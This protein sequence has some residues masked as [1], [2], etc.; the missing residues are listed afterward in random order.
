[1]A[2][3]NRILFLDAQVFADIPQIPPKAFTAYELTTSQED[4]QMPHILLQLLF[5]SDELCFEILLLGL[6]GGKFFLQAELFAVPD[7]VSQ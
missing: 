7:V 4:V 6:I 2:F 1:M 3:D 5:S